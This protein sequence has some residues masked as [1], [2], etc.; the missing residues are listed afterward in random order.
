MDENLNKK[1][2][3]LSKEVSKL[4]QSKLRE[5]DEDE[6]SGLVDESEVATLGPGLHIVPP[7]DVN[8]PLGQSKTFSVIIKHYEPIDPLLS[9]EITSSDATRAQPRVPQ[10][11]LKRLSTNG[12]T[13][14]TTFA[15]E[16][17]K[18]GR[19]IVVEARCGIYQDM[20]TVNV[21]PLPPPIS[22]PDGLSFERTTYTL[23][24]NKEKAL[25]VRLKGGANLG[26]RAIVHLTSDHPDIIVKDGGRVELR[27]RS[28]GDT[29]VGECRVTGRRAKARGKLIAQGPHVEPAEA[30]IIVNDREL[31]SGIDITTLPVEEDF[32]SVR[33]KWDLPKN[34]YQL[35]I[36]AK[37]LS[38]R[39]YL[40]TPENGG[41]YSG[42]NDVKYHIVLAEVIAEALAFRISGKGISAKRPRRVA[43]LLRHR[44]SLSQTLF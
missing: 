9:V 29:W 15:L 17:R 26:D 1:L 33:Y 8:L 42:V 12:T 14:R 31:Q 34:P 38:I 13:A 40:G 18:L 27:R 3:D 28:A 10:V 6:P 37:H 11:Q 19:E 44:F 25:R 43:E 30:H 20:I 24:V 7:G 2:N 35:L 21:V 41:G 5:L 22:V 36:G 4:F 32:G 39:R 16:G 23:Q